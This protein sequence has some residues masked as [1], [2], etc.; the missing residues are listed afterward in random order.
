MV[1]PKGRKL[2]PEHRQKISEG[3][4]GKWKG[5]KNPNWN[6]GRLTQSDGRILLL[7]PDHPHAQKKGYMRRSR[8]VMEKYLGRYLKPEEIVHHRNEILS[9]DREKNLRVFSN[10]GSHVKFHKGLRKL[11]TFLA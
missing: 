2:S 10:V 7:C 11:R 3:R 6:G 8:L 1:W 5:E 4:R 9:D